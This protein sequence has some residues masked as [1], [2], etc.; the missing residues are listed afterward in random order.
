[1]PPEATFRQ[2][3]PVYMAKL[4]MDFPTL[5]KL[6]A[7]AMFGNLGYESLGFTKLQEIAPKAGRGGLGWGQWTATR[8]RSFET[9]AK[10]N[11][12]DTSAPETNYKFLFVEL[13]GEEARAISALRAKT[14]L[15]E[16]VVAFEAAY[17][18]AGVKNY[19]ERQ[20]WARIAL[21][22]FEAATGKPA[23]PVPSTPAPAPPEP[24]VNWLAALINLLLAF[25]K[26]LRK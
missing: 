24:P 23:Q 12:L 18:R 25:L 3:A 17:E 15:D 14:T 9:Y 11:G 8:R 10:R 21:D 26:G 4:L 2:L 13:K 5:N 22:A 19:P 6:D 20:R 1:M 7:A 16:K